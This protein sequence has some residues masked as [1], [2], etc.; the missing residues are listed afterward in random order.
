MTTQLQKTRAAKWMGAQYGTHGSKGKDSK[1]DPVAMLQGCSPFKLM[2][3]K[4]RA[5]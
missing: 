4:Y 2:P 5:T 3:M 1:F